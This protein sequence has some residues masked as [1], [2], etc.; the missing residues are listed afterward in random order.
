[1]HALDLAH[2]LGYAFRGFNHVRMAG[3][4]AIGA[5][6]KML[7]SGAEKASHMKSRYALIA[8]GVLVAGGATAAMLEK[9][10]P[11]EHET[12]L[13]KNG[14]LDT[15]GNPSE[16]FFQNF[17]A[18]GNDVKK[19]VLDTLFSAKVDKQGKNPDVSFD[20]V[21]NE[22]AIVTDKASQ[23]SQWQDILD[24]D[25]SFRDQLAK[26]GIDVKVVSREEIEKLRT[27]VKTDKAAL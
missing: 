9:K 4:P 16:K 8:A 27:L 22:Y 19:E 5:L 26:F 6:S 1:M 11:E 23:R 17:S 21:H 13:K 14:W 7:A 3:K 24:A 18:L 10:T 25:S 20:P 12:E 2:S 15:L